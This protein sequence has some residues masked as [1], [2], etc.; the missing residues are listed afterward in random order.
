MFVLHAYIL[1]SLILELSRPFCIYFFRRTC[2]NSL[3]CQA[4]SL[5]HKIF[6]LALCCTAEQ[7]IDTC[8]NESVI[9]FLA[10]WRL[11]NV[12][13]FQYLQR[14]DDKLIVYCF[15][16]KKKTQKNVPMHCCRHPSSQAKEGA[17]GRQTTK[18]AQQAGVGGQKYLPGQ[19]R[20]GAPRNSPADWNE[21]CQVSSGVFFMF[22]SG[23]LMV[24]VL[25]QLQ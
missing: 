7:E 19:K 21:T 6:V 20:P 15:L 12:I 9:G 16:K 10:A 18:Q 17:A 25:K 1:A 24:E 22:L 2:E 14:G 4:D 11:Y 13:F 3:L 5:H 23:E 8:I